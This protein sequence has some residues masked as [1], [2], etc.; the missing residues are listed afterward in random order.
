MSQVDNILEGSE[1]QKKKKK[2]NTVDNDLNQQNTC[3]HNSRTT[4]QVNE[5]QE[6]QEDFRLVEFQ[7]EA[8]EEEDYCNN[9]KTGM[10]S[11]DS[12]KEVEGEKGT[13]RSKDKDQDAETD[14]DTDK[15]KV[16]YNGVLPFSEWLEGDSLAPPS[17]TAYACLDGIV[18]LAKINSQDSFLDLGCGDGRVVIG[19]SLRTQCRGTGIDIESKCIQ[20]FNKRIERWQSQLEDKVQ[21]IEGDILDAKVYEKFI[22]EAT[23]VY[24]YLLPEGLEEASIL[25]KKLEERIRDGNCKVVMNTWTPKSWKRD[26]D[27]SWYGNNTNLYLFDKTSMIE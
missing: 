15:D 2:Q 22:N 6:V 14:A 7:E 20:K 5:V 4:N 17:P 10:F 25:I 27:K 11:M 12:D 1:D 8:Q 19:L 13:D 24:L 9:H 18:D 21:A 23:I 26:K 3:N 16:D